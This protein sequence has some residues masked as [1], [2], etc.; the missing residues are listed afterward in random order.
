MAGNVHE[1]AQR[2]QALILA[3]YDETGP[4]GGNKET[5]DCTKRIDIIAKTTIT[6]RFNSTFCIIH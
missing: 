3:K 5:E 6:A 2:A 4:E 1:L